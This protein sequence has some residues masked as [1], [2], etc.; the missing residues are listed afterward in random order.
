MGIMR[1]CNVLS[2][3]WMAEDVYLE[4][5]KKDADFCELQELFKQNPRNEG[6]PDPAC[7]R[8]VERGKSVASAD[9]KEVGSRNYNGQRL[10][11]I[12]VCS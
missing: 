9:R 4:L 10:R 5:Q 6:P 8:S 2:M 1:V 12:E 11:A 3:T 7:Q